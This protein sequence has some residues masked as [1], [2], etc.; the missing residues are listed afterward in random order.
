MREATFL[1]TLGMGRERTWAGRGNGEGEGMGSEGKIG[2]GRE[3][4]R[5]RE[6]IG[7]RRI[8]AIRKMREIRNGEKWGMKERIRR[9]KQFGWNGEEEG[10]K[11]MGKK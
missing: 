6:N 5:I 11:E 3:R 9:K 1:S 7:K 4:M 10:R 8:N 2:E